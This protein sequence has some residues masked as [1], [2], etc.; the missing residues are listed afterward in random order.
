MGL[1]KQWIVSSNH[2]EI[3]LFLEDDIVVS[4]HYYVFLK[5]AIKYYYLDDENYDEKMFGMSLQKQQIILGKSNRKNEANIQTVLDKFGSPNFF[6]YQ[7]LGM[8]CVVLNCS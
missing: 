5:E 4:S 3:Q 8:L 6:K 2:S 1:L 7:L